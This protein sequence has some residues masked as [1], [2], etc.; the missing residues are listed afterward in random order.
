MSGV[1]VM[2][3]QEES[4]YKS[5]ILGLTCTCIELRDEN[6]RLRKL[7]CKLYACQKYTECVD[8]PYVDDPSCYFEDELREFGI[9]VN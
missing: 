5:M 7:V 9:E 4:D 1:V 8:C 6:T 3:E 2:S